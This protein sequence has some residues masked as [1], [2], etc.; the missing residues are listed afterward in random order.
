MSP[1]ATPEAGT[2]EPS[3]CHRAATLSFSLISCRQGSHGATGGPRSWRHPDTK[4][5]VLCR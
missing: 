5:W 4:L 3:S 1:T 2:R